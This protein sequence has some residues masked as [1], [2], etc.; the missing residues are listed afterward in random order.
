MPKLEHRRDGLSVTEAAEQLGVHPNTL[1]SW[2][3][4]GKI[5]VTR[6]PWSSRPNA[7]AREIIRLHPDDVS[8]LKTRIDGGTYDAADDDSAATSGAKD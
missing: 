6:F 8:A 3:R 2:I 7:R 1:R 5:A 4:A